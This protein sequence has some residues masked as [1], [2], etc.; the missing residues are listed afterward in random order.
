[1]KE[2]DEE[3]KETDENEDGVRRLKENK[4]LRRRK[5]VRANRGNKECEED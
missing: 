2:K 5:G 4:G 1:M 3:E